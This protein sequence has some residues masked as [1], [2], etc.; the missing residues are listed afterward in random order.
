[1]RTQS[2][3]G[4][5]LVKENM[6]R[7]HE[8][9]GMLVQEAGQGLMDVGHFTLA[10]DYIMLNYARREGKFTWELYERDR[11]FGE[12]AQYYAYESGAEVIMTRDAN[13][14]FRVEITMAGDLRESVDPTMDWTGRSVEYEA[15]DNAKA[16]TIKSLMDK[17][18]ENGMGANEHKKTPDWDSPAE[19]I[20]AGEE[21][22]EQDVD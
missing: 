12:H 18:E 4:T 1:M 6:H 7:L 16:E 3:G 14:G 22:G 20:E 13:T 8:R 10:Y 9:L 5:T 11:V 2:A 21:E 17:L 15:R 19:G